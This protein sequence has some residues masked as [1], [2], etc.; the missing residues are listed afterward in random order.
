MEKVNVYLTVER[1][2]QK[3]AEDHK[4]DY[5][6]RDEFVDSFQLGYCQA[7]FCGLIHQVMAELGEDRAVD[8]LERVGITPVYGS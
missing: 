8:M 3:A 6:L 7:A 5:S 1:T 4:R 2:L